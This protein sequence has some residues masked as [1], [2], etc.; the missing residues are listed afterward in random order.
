MT[1]PIT[2]AATLS[3][4]EA[5][6][7]Q[8]LADHRGAQVGRGHVLEAAAVGAD[9]GAYRMAKNDLSSGHADSPV[10]ESDAERVCVPPMDAAEVRFGVD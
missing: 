2:S 6:A 7:L 5:G 3:A 4:G 10:C 8:R 9:G 1:L